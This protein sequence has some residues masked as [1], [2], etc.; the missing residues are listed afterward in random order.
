MRPVNCIRTFF[1]LTATLITIGGK[2]EANTTY[3]LNPILGND[4]STLTG[5]ITT[6]GATG[7]LSS[8]DILEASFESPGDLFPTTFKDNS[9]SDVVATETGLLFSD[10]AANLS[11]YNLDGSANEVSLYATKPASWNSNLLVSETFP[12]TT[13]P[14]NFNYQGYFATAPAPVPEPPTI[15]LLGTVILGLLAMQFSRRRTS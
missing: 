9:Q 15:T 12:P 7:P 5:T 1:C 3:T 8:T 13:G 2:A 10:A 4:G 6:D 11:F 14:M